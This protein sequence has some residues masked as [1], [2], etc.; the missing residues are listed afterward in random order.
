MKNLFKTSAAIFSVLLVASFGM[1][2]HLMSAGL[3]VGAGTK[4]Y[5]IISKSFVIEEVLGGLLTRKVDYDFKY[6]GTVTN[7]TTTHFSVNIGAITISD[8]SQ[9]SISYL[10]HKERYLDAEQFHL[11]RTMNIPQDKFRITDLVEPSQA[12]SGKAFASTSSWGALLGGVFLLLLAVF[13]G[14]FLARKKENPQ[15]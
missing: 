14:A 10:Q 13:F 1:S 5:F 7:S 2:T 15:E 3:Q 4:G 9:V 6:A 11:G 8:P 12:G